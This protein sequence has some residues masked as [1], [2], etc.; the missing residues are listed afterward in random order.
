MKL[1]PAANFIVLR[2]E[3]PL[4]YSGLAIALWCRAMNSV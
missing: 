4:G 2:R 3:G 1:A